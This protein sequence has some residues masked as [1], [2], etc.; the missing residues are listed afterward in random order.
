MK[1]FITPTSADGAELSF[2]I[3]A[4]IGYYE[5]SMGPHYLTYTRAVDRF[6]GPHELHHFNVGLS[7]GRNKRVEDEAAG[8]VVRL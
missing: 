7:H 6:L 4:A 3:G 8:K 1:R 2:Q 5:G